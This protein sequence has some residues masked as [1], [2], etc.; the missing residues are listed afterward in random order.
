[1]SDRWR[2]RWHARL[3]ALSAAPSVL[4]SAAFAIS[5]ARLFIDGRSLLWA[6]AAVTLSEAVATAD[7]GE[8]MRL[9]S[10]GADPNAR[11][12]VADAGGS[13]E[14]AMLT[15]LEAAVITRERYMLDVVLDYGGRIDEGNAPALQCLAVAVG[16]PELAAAMAAESQGASRAT[17][18][19]VDCVGVPLPWEP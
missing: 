1:M 2:S 11:Y 19:P 13:G 7:L 18:R 9:L 15:P 17:N 6:P 5:G 14:P 12:P 4:V 16:A 8:T 10:E 3:I